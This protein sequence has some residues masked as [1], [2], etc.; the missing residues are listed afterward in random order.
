MSVVFTG[1]DLER[2]GKALGVKVHREGKSARYEL[3]D[4]ISGRS[5]T[6]EIF[7]DL[8]IPDQKGDGGPN[9]LLTVEIAGSKLQL[10]GCTSFVES[11][12]LG[13]VIFFAERKG[14]TSGLVLE[15]QAACSLYA[16]FDNSLRSADYTRIAP[17]LVM[18]ALTLSLTSEILSDLP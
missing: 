10:Q 13:E 18:G 16:N 12:D 11:E 8:A 15:R 2:I 6:L 1:K 14:V 7:V 9:N 17:E 4:E 3:H 5:L